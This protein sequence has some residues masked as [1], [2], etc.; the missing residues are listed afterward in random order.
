VSNIVPINPYPGHPLRALNQ[1]AEDA[2][3]FV[4]RYEALDDLPRVIREQAKALHDSDQIDKLFAEAK[5]TAT[6]NEDEEAKLAWCEAALQRFDPQGNYEENDREGDL[7]R[8]VIAD[9]IA[10]L[11]GAFPNANP[12][13]P[14]VYV[15]NLIEN[16]SSVAL[17]L[18]ALDAAI[19]EIVGTKKFVPAVSEVMEVVNEQCA[20]WEAR[21]SAI[22]GLADESRR[23]VARLDG[24]RIEMLEAAKAQAAKAKQAAKMRAVEL[25]R[26]KLE[27]ARRA[28]I[29]AEDS[30]CEANTVLRE[31]EDAVAEAKRRVLECENDLNTVT[32]M[33]EDQDDAE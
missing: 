2:D 5:R 31:A 23:I 4:R 33:L 9:R 24:M 13:D 12:S 7:K 16:V 18:P 10:V 21:F 25:A 8:A 30:Y 28:L 17:T 22:W 32:R 29:D 20:K 26:Q 3:R 19:W 15:R 6:L 14:E 1:F 11:L 27:Q